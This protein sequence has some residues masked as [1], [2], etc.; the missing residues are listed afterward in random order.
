MINTSNNANTV[1]LDELR[2]KMKQ[3]F[4]SGKYYQKL[5]ATY[6]RVEEPNEYIAIAREIGATFTCIYYDN[7]AD[8]FIYNKYSNVTDFISDYSAQLTIGKILE[9]LIDI[10]DQKLKYDANAYV[11]T[12][13]IDTFSHDDYNVDLYLKTTN[14]FQQVIEFVVSN[15]AQF[16]NYPLDYPATDAIETFIGYIRKLI[17]NKTVI[18]HDNMTAYCAQILMALFKQPYTYSGVITLVNDY[19][20]IELPIKYLP[21]IKDKVDLQFQ[22]T[23]ADDLDLLFNKLVHY[24]LADLQQRISNSHITV[25]ING[26]QDLINHWLME[27]RQHKHND[28]Y[29][30]VNDILAMISQ[31]T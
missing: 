14:N 16:D 24:S 26:H 9:L 12:H 17:K 4:L 29:Q 6:H 22:I 21:L 28:Y 1:T 27:I 30:K 23:S 19:L 15:L 8:D 10:D 7:H 20:N 11:S 18:V 2:S 13:L 31:L 5:N 3:L 25:D